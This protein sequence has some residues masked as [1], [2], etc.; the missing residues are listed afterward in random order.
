MDVEGR[1]AV[2]VWICRLGGKCYLFSS[3]IKNRLLWQP[4]YLISKIFRIF[5]K[6]IFFAHTGV[7]H[8]QSQLVHIELW[9]FD[10]PCEERQSAMNS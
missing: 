3:P 8:F 7:L 4:A 6:N 5:K 10:R 1:N 9:L 2:W